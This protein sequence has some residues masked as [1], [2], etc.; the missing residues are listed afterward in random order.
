MK[1]EG[2]YV[3]VRSDMAG[4]FYGE[5]V[6]E[7][8]NGEIWLRNAR[9]LWGWVGAETCLDLSARGTVSPDQCKLTAPHPGVIGVTPDSG[10]YICTDEARASLDAVP[11]WGVGT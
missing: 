9:Q 7:E 10:V 5:V 6:E 8:E 3:I 2:I 1:L 11:H 4:V